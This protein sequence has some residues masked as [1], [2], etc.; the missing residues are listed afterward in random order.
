MKSFPK[1]L[2]VAI[3]LFVLAA[4]TGG[5]LWFWT[6]GQ[7]SQS[8][9]EKRQLD[10]RIRSVSG[11]G[12]YPN[13]S[14]LDQ[15]M[16]ATDEIRALTDPVETSI[17]Q[18]AQP[19]D[20]VR[21]TLNDEGQYSGLPANEWKR[22]LEEKRESILNLAQQKNVSLPEVFYLGFDRYRALT[23]TE[24]ATYH[25]G[26][27]LL[28][29]NELM[30][31]ALDSGVVEF[32]QVKRVFAEDNNTNQSGDG[33]AAVL[34]PGPEAWYTIYP[35]EIK[36]TGVAN[37]V[38]RLTNALTQ[39]GFYFVLRSVDVENEKTSVPRRTEVKS[40]AT[41]DGAQKNIIPIVGEENIKVTMRIDLILW[42]AD[43]VSE[44]VAQEAE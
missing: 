36:F 16:A 11:K 41:G 42:N 4:L 9:E 34:A 20:S 8:L 22:L 32:Q 29:I 31:I 17:Q 28:A 40:Q 13:Q 30:E 6:G 38:S 23:P 3:V 35:F 39:S 37:S 19:F 15:I 7:L 2:L 5:G 25:L 14:N 26:V 21:G 43:A 18:T 44:V 12:V 27:Q 24:D 33:L 1:H 10:M